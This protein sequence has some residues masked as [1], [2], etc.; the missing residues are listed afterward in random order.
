[1]VGIVGDEFVRNVGSARYNAFSVNLVVDIHDFAG[2]F[3][4]SYIHFTWHLI[5]STNIALFNLYS[6]LIL[7][8]EEEELA[9]ILGWIDA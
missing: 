6:V 5:V 1:M 8:R 2:Y 3:A 4:S 7:I 9:N